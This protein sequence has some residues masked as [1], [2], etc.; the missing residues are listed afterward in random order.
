ML[1]RGWLGGGS[2]GDEELRGLVICEDSQTWVIS[3]EDCDKIDSSIFAAIAVIGTAVWFYFTPHLVAQEMAS[4]AEERNATK[5][6]RHINFPSLR[7]SVKAEV[8]AKLAAE[9]RLYGTPDPG[10]ASFYVALGV[11]SASHF[12]CVFAELGGCNE[13]S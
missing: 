13:A 2:G 8:T 3:H 4:A 5:L 12:I 9:I 1:A 6:S 11:S 7:E 10:L